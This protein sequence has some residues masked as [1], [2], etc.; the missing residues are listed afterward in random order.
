M[1]FP[2]RHLIDGEQ[3]VLDRHPHWAMFA[4]RTLLFAVAV[5]LGIWALSHDY[6]PGS[7][8]RRPL[9]YAAAVAVGVTLLALLYRLWEWRSISFVVTTERCI[10]RV[11]M[12]KKEGVEVPLQRITS[13][14]FSQSVLDRMLGRGDLTIESDG[15]GAP[16][17]FDDIASPVKV[18][19]LIYHQIDRAQNRRFDRMAT[20]GA[21]AD[22]A[23][24][25]T[26]PGATA[27]L[28]VAEQLES[29]PTCTTG[30]HHLGRVRHPAAADPRRLT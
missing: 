1:A 17:V 10:Q 16:R 3:I 23:S 28:S 18:Q 2:R 26:P 29:C 30:G 27:S 20:G 25:G 5:G 15:E 8:Y 24:G 19:K 12:L 9:Q 13:V 11:S 22:G 21:P 6:Q 4:P 14:S 7:N